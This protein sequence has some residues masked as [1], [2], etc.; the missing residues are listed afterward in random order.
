MTR[1]EKD[2]FVFMQIAFVVLYDTALMSEGESRKAMATL[3]G[4]ISAVTNNSLQANGIAPIYPDEFG[5]WLD[6][7]R[8]NPLFIHTMG[9]PNLN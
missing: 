3:L 7:I 5:R 6:T 1:D 8:L 2:Y 4:H 9:D